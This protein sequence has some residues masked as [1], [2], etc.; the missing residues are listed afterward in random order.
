[1]KKNV[2]KCEL[3][4]YEFHE[5]SLKYSLFN[6]QKVTHKYEAISVVLKLFWFIAH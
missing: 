4:I 6:P 5:K 3:K 1:M 2:G